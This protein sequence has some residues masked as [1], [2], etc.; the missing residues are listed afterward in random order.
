MRSLEARYRTMREK[1]PEQ[2]S[3]YICFVRAIIGQKFSYEIVSK[4]YNIHVDKDDYNSRD[5]NN[6]VRFLH[7]LS[8]MPEE[9]EFSGKNRP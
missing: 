1:Y 8:N 4:W 9:K 3:S 7:K 5:R 2:Y 6:I